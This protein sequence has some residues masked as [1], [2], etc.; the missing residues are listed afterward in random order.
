MVV[1]Y[2]LDGDSFVPGK[3]RL[4]TDRHL[5]FTL[6]SGSLDLH[7]DGK[8]L[9]VTEPAEPTA[10]EKRTVHVTM[11]LNFFDYLKRRIP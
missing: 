9:V 7:P 3:P 6:G 8:R 10:A 1:D 5:F 11:L 2:N 4:W